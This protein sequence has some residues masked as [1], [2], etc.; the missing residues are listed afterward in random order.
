[1]ENVQCI[2][3]Q[4]YI[5]L[6]NIECRLALGSTKG[7]SELNK[8]MLGEHE[9]ATYDLRTELNGPHNDRFTIVKS[10]YECFYSYGDNGIDVRNTT[11]NC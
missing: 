1:M 8:N 11:V 9:C 10:R 4:Y 6:C 5:P 7:R 2:Q 3:S